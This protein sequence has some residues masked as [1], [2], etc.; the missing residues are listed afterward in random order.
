MF[1]SPDPMKTTAAAF[2]QK[3]APLIVVLLGVAA[4]N[5]SAQAGNATWTGSIDGTWVTGS[6]W[7]TGAAPG[8]T[9]VV[10]N[11]DQAWFMA[12]G[13]TIT[14]DTNRDIYHIYF[15]STAGSYT[16]NGGPLKLTPGGSININVTSLNSNLTETFNTPILLYGGYTFAVSGTLGSSS[17]VFNGPISTGTTGLATLNLNTSIIGGG[18]FISVAGPITDGSGVLALNLV[19]SING[20]MAGTV[21]LTGTNSY[22]GGTGMVSGSLVINSMAALGNFATTGTLALGSFGSNTGANSNFVYTGTGDQANGTIVMS[23]LG[24]GFVLI[25]QSGSGLLKFNGSLAEVSTTNARTVFFQ[26]STSGTGQYAGAISD[27]ASVGGISVVKTGTG[28]WILSGSNSYTGATSG[29][30]GVLNVQNNTALGSGTV[31]VSS[32]AALQLQSGISVGNV[33]S[34]AGPGINNDGALRSVSGSN[35]YTGPISFTGA[36]RINADAGTLYLTTGGIATGGNDLTLGGSGNMV[37]ASILSGVGVFTKDGPGIVTLTS[38]NSFAGTI[39][40][41]AGTLSVGDGTAGHDGSIATSSGIAV[42]NTTSFLVYNLSSTASRTYSNVISGLGSLTVTGSGTLTLTATNTYTGPTLVSGGSL[43]LTNTGALGASAINDSSIAGGISLTL[44]G[45]VASIGG[46]TGTSTGD[47]TSIFSNHASISTLVLNPGA[48]VSNSS[49]SI[50]SDGTSSNHMNLTKTG[51][52]TQVLTGL[53]TYTGVTT[54][55]SGTLSVSHLANGGLASGIGQSDSTWSNLVFNG[56]TLQYTG[57]SVGI[58]RSGTLGASSAINVSTAGTVLTLNGQINDVKLNGRTITKSGAGTL[59]LSGTGNNVAFMAVTSGT[60]QLSKSAGSACMAL[61]TVSQG[62]VVQL[63]STI[64]QF[65]GDNSGYNQLANMNGILDLNGNSATTFSDIAATSSGTITNTASS[66]TA[67]FT[68]STRYNS[69]NALNAWTGSMQDGPNGGKLGFTYTRYTYSAGS[70]T[71]GGSNTYS[72]NTTISSATNT[73]LAASTTAFSPNSA[74]VFAAGY[75]YNTLSLNGFSNTIGSLASILT[76]NTTD[77]TTAT[78]TTGND[79]TNTTFAGTITG[80]GNLTKTGTGTFTLTGSNNNY[81]GV[82]TVSAGTLVVSGSLSATASVSVAAAATLNVS[83]SI[84]NAAAISVAGTLM[85]TG[86]VGAVNVSA[87]GQLAPGATAT[88]GTLTTAGSV[89]FA[90]ST[91]KLSIRLGS[92]SYDQ[93]KLGSGNYTVTL[94]SAVLNLTLSG[95]SGNVGDKFVIIDGGSSIA[96]TVISGKFFQPDSITVGADTFDILYNVDSS[97]TGLGNDVV[98][99]LA[100][101]PEPNSLLILVGGTAMLLMCQRARR[102]AGI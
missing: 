16:F 56:G 51:S 26:G 93:L 2:I 37:V 49:S 15:D 75:Y 61:S 81:T 99:R 73:L 9:S 55:S 52:G 58:D 13:T 25:N 50:I 14:V 4:W 5:S 95:F 85:G 7:A 100:S 39:S 41:S 62:A 30:A 79:N 18:G 70:C 8:S 57:G 82:T 88:N 76:S 33:L 3:L 29:S 66:G 77:L 48:G 54:I 19:N 22:T 91:A 44:A 68:V 80:A 12:S 38:S 24:S 74:F 53:S 1:N 40:V 46:I 28:T 98:L 83:G 64:N 34:L 35:T 42:S 97:G 101:V 31:T 78:L 43:I 17:L 86:N 92:A 60:L 94:G 21:S 90:D 32:G 11:F 102:L 67:T 72:G 87:N 63:G 20:N 84:Y 65:S 71:I 36:T 27:G 6:N 69:S 59:S 89:T 47:F 45:G 23:N 96:S 10:N